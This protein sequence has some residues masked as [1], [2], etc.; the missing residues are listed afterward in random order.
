MHAT[1]ASRTRLRVA[2]LRAGAERGPGA[3]RHY[4]RNVRGGPTKGKRGSSRA[5]PESRAECR[6]Y[7]RNGLAPLR[8]GAR[9]ARAQQRL[10]R[11]LVYLARRRRRQASHP[12][13]T[14]GSPSRLHLEHVVAASRAPDRRP[15]RAA[16]I[17]VALPS[18]RRIW[19]WASCRTRAL[20]LARE[21]RARERKVL[22]VRGRSRRPAARP[23]EF[24]Y[25]APARSGEAGVRQP[26]RARRRWG[27]R[28]R[29]PRR[30]GCAR[31]PSR[32]PT[33]SAA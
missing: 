4:G 30:V 29:G 18:L 2:S 22:D 33:S 11:R 15:R 19:V 6:D 25:T 23:G 3:A 16:E 28:Q 10:E 32:S 27:R 13:R 26:C 7:R 9:A 12:V 17:P 20:L 21:A 24:A 31:S 8:A 1:A 14:V 5:R